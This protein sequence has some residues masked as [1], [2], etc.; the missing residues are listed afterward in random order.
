MKV[1]TRVLSLA[2]IAVLLCFSLASC[3][4]KIEAGEYI[5]GDAVLTG[6]YEGYTFDGKT[7]AYNTY[8]K[9]QRQEE[10][11]CSGEYKLEIIEQEDEEEQLEDE[12]NGIKRG[13]ITFTWTD[14]NGEEKT[15]TLPII[16]DELEWTL[17]IG[18]Q[19]LVDGD[20]GNIIYTINDAG[21]EE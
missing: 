3:A 14:A 18:G 11:S 19:L 12:E 15:K 7:F 4:K 8:I 13:N 6:C 17:T 2:L 9:Y 1:F 16:I 20:Y 21:I 10:F 5:I